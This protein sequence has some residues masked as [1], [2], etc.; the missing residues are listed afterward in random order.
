MFFLHLSFSERMLLL[1]FTENGEMP[2]IFLVMTLFGECIQLEFSPNYFR[3]HISVFS[4]VFPNEFLHCS[5]YIVQ[6]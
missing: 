3:F 5:T 4:A 1:S 2:T 6:D